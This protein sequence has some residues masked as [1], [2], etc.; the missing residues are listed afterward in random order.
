MKKQ[1]VELPRNFKRLILISFDFISLSLAV[2]ASFLL[3][4]DSFFL[5]S[6]GYELTGATADHIYLTIFL[7]PIV[8]IPL[9]IISRLY[10]SVT[11][12]IGNET[13]VKI[14]KVTFLSIS[15]W[16]IIIL[17][18]EVP[19]PRSVIL[20]TFILSLMITSLSRLIARSIL[21]PKS[22]NNNYKNI[23]LYGI[24]NEV[25]EI[26]DILKKYEK[27]K[28]HGFVTEAKDSKGVVIQDRPVYLL[29][30][31]ESVISYKNIDEVFL[32]DNQNDKNSLRDKISKYL[33][34]DFSK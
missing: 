25:I 12:H 28:L 18:L 16:S 4:S 21:Q 5:P 3:R 19:I 14:L 17:L 10:R 23:L 33:P 20:I 13:Y 24:D 11:R 1:I 7:L 9:F 26:A 34:R 30:D 32:V 31:I 8:S 2:Y 29:K 15:T 22:Q 6:N 27:V